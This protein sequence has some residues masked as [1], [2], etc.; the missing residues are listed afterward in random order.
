M[1]DY[2]DIFLYVEPSLHLWDEAD[3]IMVYDCSET[4]S[5]IIASNS[6]KYLGVTLTK[7]V[8]DLYDKNLKSLKKEIEED[9][10]K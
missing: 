2:A 8:E 1:V 6:I 10:R 4:T 9:N 3:L 5:F 7:Q